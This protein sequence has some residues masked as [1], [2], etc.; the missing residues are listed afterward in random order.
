VLLSVLVIM[1]YSLFDLVI[2]CYS[3]FILSVTRK[4]RV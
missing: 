4:S 1:C 3:L 2:M